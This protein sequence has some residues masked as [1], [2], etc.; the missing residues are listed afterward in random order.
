MTERELNDKFQA[1]QDAARARRHEMAEAIKLAKEGGPQPPP[2]ETVSA[3]IE[4]TVHALLDQIAGELRTIGVTTETSS[5]IE[6]LAQA[7][8]SLSC[9]PNYHQIGTP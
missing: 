4:R 7:V 3:H 8:A 2:S 1:L 5:R 6:K 9:W